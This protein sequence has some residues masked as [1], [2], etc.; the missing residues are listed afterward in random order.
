[1]LKEN[2]IKSEEIWKWF[3]KLH[4]NGANYLVNERK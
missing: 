4:S 3:D 1:M 2:I